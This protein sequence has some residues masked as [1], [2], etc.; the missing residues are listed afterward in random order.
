MTVSGRFGADWIG[1]VSGIF[2]IFCHFW[3]KEIMGLHTK[4]GSILFVHILFPCLNI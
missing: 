1:I 2:M 4:D 3:M